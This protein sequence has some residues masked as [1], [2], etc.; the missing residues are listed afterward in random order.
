[1][2]LGN[3]IDY[4][5][6]VLYTKPRQKKDCLKVISKMD[7]EMVLEEKSMIKIW[8]MLVIGNKIKDM[9][10]VYLLKRKKWSLRVD[11]RMEKNIKFVTISL[12]KKGNIGLKTLKSKKMNII[13]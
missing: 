4:M 11:G 1:M 13:L 3:R 9:E 2:V 7:K 5:D 12:I 10:R 6:S 8:Y